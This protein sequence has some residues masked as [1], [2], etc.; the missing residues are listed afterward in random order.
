M[1]YTAVSDISE[2]HEDLKGLSHLVYYTAVSDISECHEGLKGLSHLVYYTAVSDI[3]ECHEGLK[4]L[5]HL[6][7]CTAV[8]DINECYE[9]SHLCK[10]DQ[11]CINNEGSYECVQLCPRGFVRTASGQC[12]GQLHSLN[13]LAMEV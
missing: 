13:N 8:S 5:S 1:Y 10:A 6:V 9:G 4:G 11:E 3:S 7:Y 12:Q 2:C